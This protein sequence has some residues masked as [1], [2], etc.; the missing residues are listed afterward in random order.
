MML[1]MIPS[2]PLPAMTFSTFRSN[3]RASTLRSA[4]PPSGYRCSRFK[5]AFDGLDR[6]RRSTKRI[7]VRAELGYLF[8]SESLLDFLD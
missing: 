5:L 7:L 2:D 8:D 3:I 4:R 6:K 1:A